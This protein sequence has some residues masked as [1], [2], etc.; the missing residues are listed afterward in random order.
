MNKFLTILLICVGLAIPFQ[1]SNDIQQIAQVQDEPS[2]A[3][4]NMKADPGTG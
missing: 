2:I 3:T 4:T 1:E